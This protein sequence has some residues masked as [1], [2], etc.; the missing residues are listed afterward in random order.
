MNARETWKFEE[1]LQLYSTLIE[2]E[3]DRVRISIS[4]KR[5]LVQNRHV[6][7]EVKSFR[8]KMEFSI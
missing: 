8:T 7:R 4:G 6:S 5:F 3:H 1:L 2:E